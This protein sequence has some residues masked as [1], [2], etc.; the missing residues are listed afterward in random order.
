MVNLWPFPSPHHQHPSRPLPV[1]PQTPPLCHPQLLLLL[2]RLRS[3]GRSSRT[4]AAAGTA[5]SVATL[6]Y[7]APTS[8]GP[9][10][11]VV[12]PT[13]TKPFDPNTSQRR[14]CH[15]TTRRSSSIKPSAASFAKCKMMPGLG[16]GK[17]LAPIRVLRYKP[18]T[19]SIMFSATC[20]GIASLT[21]S[22]TDT[23]SSARS[24]SSKLRSRG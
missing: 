18:S 7:P 5:A 13:T 11:E 16:S 15:S 6:G 14:C 19:E 2:R 12:T 21:P 3:P 22:T 24:D 4:N 17:A 20:S 8:N 9:K 1:G 10:L 23:Q